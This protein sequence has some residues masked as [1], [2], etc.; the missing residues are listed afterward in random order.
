[1]EA[2]KSWTE[3]Y[4]DSG[5]PWRLWVRA[6][7]LLSRDHTLRS[8]AKHDTVKVK[9]AMLEEWM[10]HEAWVEAELQAQDEWHRSM[11]AKARAL[12]E[13]VLDGRVKNVSGGTVQVIKFFLER[14]DARYRPPAKAKE[15]AQVP[16]VLGEVPA[17]AQRE[18][19][20]GALPEDLDPNMLFADAPEA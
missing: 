18:P 16:I 17:G 19:T 8:A 11:T 15:D 10:E 12:S 13:K 7:Y 9:K 20:D 6:A 4:G 2:P 3:D 5:I 1:M 14:G